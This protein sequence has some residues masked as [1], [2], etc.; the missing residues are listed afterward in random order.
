MTLLE[1]ISNGKYNLIL[2]GIL[3]VFIFHQYWNKNTEPMADVGN[4]DQIKEAVKQVYM[5][6]V[7]SIRNLSNVA[8]QLQAGGLTIPGN[9]TVKGELRAESG[10]ILMGTVSA[11]MWGINV[12]QTD[13]GTFSL[14]RVGRDGK[15]SD[16]SGIKLI[17]SADGTQNMGGMFSLMPSGTVVAWSGNKVP[18]GWA[19]CD[20]QNKTPDLRGRFIIGVGKAEKLTERKLNDVGGDETIKLTIDNLPAHSHKY[21]DA[22]Y[23]EK[24]GN[25]PDYQTNNMKGSGDSDGDNRPWILGRKT[26]PVGDNKPF[27]SMPPFYA[28]A[29]IIKL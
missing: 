21:V 25:D 6:D 27:G 19:L 9:L 2:F 11:N 29:Y 13:D 4:L 18:A 1:E 22:Y 5:A 8:T 3:F 16:Q 7:E 23:S 10:K 28:L 12:N 14:G 20:G 26:E 15:P 17:T 24:N